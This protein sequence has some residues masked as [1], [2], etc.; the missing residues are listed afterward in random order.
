MLVWYVWQDTISVHRP[1]FYSQRFQIFFSNTVFKKIPS[2]MRLCLAYLL[3][4]L[5][6]VIAVTVWNIASLL[7]WPF[8]QSAY[9]PSSKCHPLAHT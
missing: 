3:R 9:C 2:R 8:T 4:L 6:T 7:Q 5:I 1:G